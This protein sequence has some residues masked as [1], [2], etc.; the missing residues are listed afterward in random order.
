MLKPNIKDFTNR[1]LLKFLLLRSKE[2]CISI[3][4]YI[5]ICIYSKTHVAFCTEDEMRA[6]MGVLSFEDEFEYPKVDV[7]LDFSHAQYYENGQVDTTT[8]NIYS[9]TPPTYI[10]NEITYEL[11]HMDSLY[12][13]YLR[14]KDFI[15]HIWYG[16]PKDSD[17]NSY[18]EESQIA[19]TEASDVADNENPLDLNSP[20]VIFNN[21]Q[22]YIKNCQTRED[23]VRLS[24]EFMTNM[25]PD[26]LL[27]HTREEIN[28]PESHASIFQQLLLNTIIS[29][30]SYDEL[31]RE[32]RKSVV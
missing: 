10:Q 21:Y 11:N 26:T 30:D 16:T 4:W 31:T 28:L 9:L 14:I 12:D 7:L 17:S 25:F 19:Y 3:F 22:N 24:F 1:M 2:I 32:D 18:T 29:K 5:V 8:V 23:V 6:I 13:K 20:D 27:A 15:L